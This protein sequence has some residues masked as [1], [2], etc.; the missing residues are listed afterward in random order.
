MNPAS[1]VCEGCAR[2]S[3]E[4]ARWL[5]A[6]DEEK[7]AILEAVEKRRAAGGGV[8]LGQKD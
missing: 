2:T 1:G 4:I 6:S 7:R 8:N 5:H 3:D